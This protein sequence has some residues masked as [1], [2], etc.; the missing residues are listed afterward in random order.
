M[1]RRMLRESQMRESATLVIARH[2]KHGN[3]AI[4]DLS[5]R[6]KRLPRDAAWRTRPVEYVSAMYDEVDIAVERGLQRGRVVGQEVVPTPSS[7]D[8][9]IYRQVVAEVCVCQQ[10]DP[11]D[12]AH[13]ETYGGGD[14]ENVSF[15]R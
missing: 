11:Y 13:T 5:Q 3:A 14:G 8:A 6:F 2:D 4:G 10:Q 15:P 7:I 9:W 12:V 1:Y